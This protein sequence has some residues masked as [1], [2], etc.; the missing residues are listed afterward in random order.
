MATSAIIFYLIL[1]GLIILGQF[2]RIELA[3]WPG[4][5]LLDMVM[6]MWGGWLVLSQRQK[7]IELVRRTLLALGRLEK[8][9]IIWFA[10]GWMVALLAGDFSE[11]AI[12]YLG[13]FLIYGG[14]LWLVANLHILPQKLLR[15]GLIVAGCYMLLWGLG[16]YWLLPDMRFLTVFGWDDHY[17]RLVGTQLD[18]NFMGLIF[19]L[20]FI[21]LWHWPGKNLVQRRLGWLLETLT[22]VGIGLTFSRSTFLSFGLV[23]LFLAGRQW[24]KYWPLVVLLL[25]LILANKP[26]SEGV[27]LTRTASIEARMV[28]SERSLT[29]LKPYQLILGRGLFNT[30]KTSYVSDDYRRA[31]HA[32]LPDNLWLLVV[33]GGGLVG[34][35]LVLLVSG[36]R[37]LV[38]GKRNPEGA[39][40]VLAV[41]LHAMFNNSLFQP[42]I[43]L[44]LGLTLISKV[45]R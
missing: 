38:L 18:P 20:L 23:V 9:L 35:L 45:E 2:Q 37:L 7:V 31:D 11:R 43:F 25:V 32:G 34:L 39:V 6:L 16:Q 19:V 22:I 10:G 17:F 26:A 41:L 12:F 29:A 1:L 15:V 40:A 42:F 36:R 28:S 21:W 24:K 13:R 33:Q 3:P 5:Y 8:I 4:F 27:V 14:T 44:L 30:S